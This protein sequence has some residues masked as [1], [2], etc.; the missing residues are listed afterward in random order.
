M[1]FLPGCMWHVTKETKHTE[2]ALVWNVSAESWLKH[3]TSIL[4]EIL[5]FAKVWFNRK[6]ES[7]SPWKG[8]SVGRKK[9]EKIIAG[10]IKPFLFFFFLFFPQCRTEEQLLCLLSIPAAMSRADS[11][12]SELLPVPELPWLWVSHG[13]AQPAGS[14]RDCPHSSITSGWQGTNPAAADLLLP[15]D[16]RFIY[17][18]L[19]FGTK[20]CW[21]ENSLPD[22][23]DVLCVTQ[24]VPWLLPKK[25]P[26]LF[27]WREEINPFS[28]NCHMVVSE[29]WTS[30]LICQKGPWWW[31]SWMMKGIVLRCWKKQPVKMT[32]SLLCPKWQHLNTQYTQRWLSQGSVMI[33]ETNF[34]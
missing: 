32:G 14:G 21:Q 13:R 23:L 34:Y 6:N 20:V 10:K 29:P 26:V 17:L 9:K 8:K 30:I 27:V 28:A 11:N 33:C 4:Q 25:T 5:T 15:P 19:G 22:F 12:P 24:L 3:R 16:F 1:S 2:D 31:H 18:P 7:F